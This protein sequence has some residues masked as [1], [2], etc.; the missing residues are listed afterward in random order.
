MAIVLI[1]NIVACVVMGMLFP[2]TPTTLCDAK[3]NNSMCEVLLKSTMCGL[4]IYISVESYKT[5]KTLLPTF[6]CVPTFI[7]SGY[8]HVVADSFY[9][10][11]ANIINI[12]VIKYLAIA[13]IGNAI[14]GMFIPCINK[15]NSTKLIEKEK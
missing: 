12:E 6:L 9:F 15:L 14:G 4:M 3:L 11:S 5:H 10:A 1:G 2:I 8:I 13:T 7:L